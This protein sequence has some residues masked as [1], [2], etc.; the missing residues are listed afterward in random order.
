MPVVRADG[1]SGGWALY[2][3]VITKFSRMGRYFIFLPTV[4]R[5]R[6]S[7][8]RAP[9]WM[10][11]KVKFPWIEAIC[12]SSVFRLNLYSA[13]LCCILFLIDQVG[14][15]VAWRHWKRLCSRLNK[16]QPIQIIWNVMLYSQHFTCHWKLL[17][18]YVTWLMFSKMADAERSAAVIHTVP[19]EVP[20]ES[21]TDET[22][23]INDNNNCIYIALKSNNCPKRYLITK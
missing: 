15:S 5:W 10:Q 22:V 11:V 3:H 9:L 12:F 6:S 23:I 8:A 13:R 17:V 1:L 16:L 7:R 21:R 14:R 2:G 19:D 20:S 18:M 4:L